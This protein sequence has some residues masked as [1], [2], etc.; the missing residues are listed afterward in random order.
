MASTRADLLAAVERSPRLVS[1]HD[2]T[3]WV[4]LYTPDAL[5]EDPVG[6]RPHRGTGAIDRFY[7]TF[8]AP[9]DITF[10]RGVD[11]VVGNTV[12][13]DLDLE[14]GMSGGIAMR[15]PAFLRYDLAPVGGDLKITR[16]QAFW[17]LP[18]MV[19][20]FVRNGPR[21][22]PAGAALAATLLRNQ[23]AAGAAGF[24]AG[25]QGA[26]GRGKRE[27][28][29]FLGDARAGNEVAV[30]RRLAKGARITLG[31]DRPLGGT[32]LLGWLAEAQWDKVIAAGYHVVAAVRADTGP[33]VVIADVE[34]RPF[35]ITRLRVFTEAGVGGG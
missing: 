20:Q 12:I 25:L 19:G 18:G 1:A 35:V 24:L 23:G 33:G 17:E 10:H 27:F 6:A 9:R 30:R 32:D 34:T 13:R 16:L 22:V 2:R 28:V 11:A 8:I 15:I 3:G 26:G 14:V 29:A 4:G 31:E 21:A 5:I 7:A